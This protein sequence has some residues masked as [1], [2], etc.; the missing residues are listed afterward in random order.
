M[1]YTTYFDGYIEL[2]RPMD[3]ALANYIRAF[4]RSRRM[5]LDADKAAKLNDPLR[6]AAGLSIGI[7]GEFCVVA[8]DSLPDRNGKVDAV[9][10][11]YNQQPFTQPGLWCQW[12]ISENNKWIVWDEGEK[13]YEYVPWMVYFIKNFVVPFGY[14]ANGK[15]EWKG[16]ESE[17]FGIVGVQE[18][19]VFIQYGMTTYGDK[20]FV[21]G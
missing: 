2:D 3:D 7:D 8:P 4:N 11:N 9:I 17:D 5:L 10:I 20:E 12:T 15:I 18:N 16:E 14:V 21:D 19:E 13:F 1:G 6:V